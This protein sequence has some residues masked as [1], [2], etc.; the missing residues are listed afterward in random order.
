M[1]VS[2]GRLGRDRT[3][4]WVAMITS[5]ENAPWPYDV[6]LPISPERT[7]LQAPS[8]VRPS[9]LATIEA[10]HAEPLGDVEPRVLEEVLGAIGEQLGSVL[11]EAAHS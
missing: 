7:G 1:I 11:N 2:A 6:A 10:S 8:V 3:L 5:A 4:L 9:K